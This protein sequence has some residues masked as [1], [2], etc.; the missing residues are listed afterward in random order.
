[1]KL[2]VV[3]GEVSGDQHATALLAALGPRVPSLEVFGVG[4]EGLK[5]AG[6]RLL[7]HQKDLAI[8][9]LVEAFSKVRFARRLIKALVAEAVREKADAAVL[10][11]SPDFNLPLAKRL[12]RAGVPVVF[13]VSPQVWAWRKRRA[14]TIARIGR[15]VLVL[16]GF[17]KRW[18]DAR[19]LGEKVTWVGHPLVDAAVRELARPAAPPPVGVRRVVLM[20]GSRKGEVESILPVLRKAVEILRRKWAD[21]EVVLVR[22]DSIPDVLLEE[23]AGP[24]IAG[25]QVVSGEHLSILRDSDVLL[26][27]SGT[28][29]VE[30]LLARVPMV[31]VYKVHP[32]TFWFARRLVKVAHVAMANIVTDDG[33]GLRT[34]PE[35]L[36]GEATPENVA[37]EAEKFLSDAALTSRTRER[38]A[39][40]AADLGPPGAGARAAEALLAAL[41]AGKAA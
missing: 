25:W 41:G 12:A 35:L 17:E 1:V 2:L 14:R 15:A 10:I 26:V 6:A 11:D 31:V 34:V 16:F 40:G 20:P 24:A 22:A 9:G 27:A 36:Q 38:L 5:A 33:T 3:A 13:Y 4:G 30:G 28:A 7:A 19:G 39:K 32:V 21:L 37:A 18:Y 29:T 8:I 23:M